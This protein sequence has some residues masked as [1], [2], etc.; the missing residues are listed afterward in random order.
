MERI[1]WHQYFMAQSHL[2]ALRSTCSRLMVGATIVREKRIIAGGYN[3][4]ISG[5]VHCIDDG[6]YVIDNHCVR[7]IHAEVN[8][9]LQCAKF[10]VATEG[11]EIYVTHFPC[12]NCCKSIIQAG[13]KKVYYATDYK[14]HPYA[15]ELFKQAGVMIEH[16]ELEEM[17]LDRNNHDK[18][19]FTAELLS[20]LERLGLDEEE[21]QT[22][23]HHANKLYTSP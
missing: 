20:Q 10:G 6:C 14:N 9:L 22:L 16:V 23:K 21:L 13:I 3:G 12:L 19:K 2:L 18:L 15:I 4:A 8:A 1:S 7:T 5:G 17:V 11:S